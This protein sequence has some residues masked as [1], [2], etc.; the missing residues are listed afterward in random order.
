MP[1][2]NEEPTSEQLAD[3]WK[4]NTEMPISSSNA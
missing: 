3:K 4:T 2:N 1:M